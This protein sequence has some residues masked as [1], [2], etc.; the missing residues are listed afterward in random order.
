MP[1]SASVFRVAIVV[2]S[3]KAASGQRADA[4]LPAMRECLPP[5]CVVATE[6]ILGD[7]REELESLLKQLAD[8]DKVD[9]ILT[10]GGTGLSPRDSTPQA[11]LAV[12]DF[13]VPGIAEAMRSGSAQRV[14]TAILS[15]AVTVVRGRTLIVNLPG[16]PQAVRQTMAIIAPVLTHAFE[17]LRGSVGDHAVLG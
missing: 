10:S 9:G 1:D 8:V 13:E 7:E 5:Q 6:K 16:S 2:L 3:D 17:V 12:A 15:R 4:C 14:P 11:T